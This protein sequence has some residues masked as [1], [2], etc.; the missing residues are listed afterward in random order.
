MDDMA[1]NQLL[2]LLG[3]IWD[4]AQLIGPGERFLEAH[5]RSQTGESEDQGVIDEH[6]RL[7]KAL[8]EPTLVSS[9]RCPELSKQA[10]LGSTPDAI[11]MVHDKRLIVIRDPDTRRRPLPQGFP[12]IRHFVIDIELVKDAGFLGV[13]LSCP[14][15]SEPHTVVKAHL[16]K[17][18]YITAKNLPNNEADRYQP[19]ETAAFAALVG[20]INPDALAKARPDI[21]MFLPPMRADAFKTAH[22]G[23]PVAMQTLSLITGNRTRIPSPDGSTSSGASVAQSDDHSLRVTEWPTEPSE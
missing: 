14:R 6:T 9:I 13:S 16:K 21:Y 17:H 20:R 11:G 12:P 10:E 7:G 1:R 18:P 3:S 23:D 19:A 8:L 5:K 2:A 15:C 22:K 4:A